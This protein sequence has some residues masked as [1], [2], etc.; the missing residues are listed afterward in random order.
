[1]SNLST[2]LPA[3]ASGKTI[4]ATA[5][6]AIATKKP[7]ILNSA[8][9]VTEVAETGVDGVDVAFGTAGVFESAGVSS[10]SSA[11]DSENNKV[12][13]AYRDEGNSSYGTAVVGTV[14]GTSISYG[15][16]VVFESASTNECAVAF[17]SN[18]NKIVIAYKD[19]GNSQY[20]TS[21]VGTVSG[22]AISF[23]S[24]VL[25]LS[26]AA[27]QAP[28]ITFDSTNN[29]VVIAYY[30]WTGSANQG[31]G[32]VGTVSGTS[33]SWG[34]AGSMTSGQSSTHQSIAYD[35][36][37]GKVVASYRNSGNSDYGTSS[38]GTVSGTSIS[39]GTPVVFEAANS[40]NTASA[41][42]SN[43]DKVVIAYTDYANSSHGTAIVGTVSGTSISFGTAVV[44]EAASTEQISAAFN[45]NT[46]KVE[47]AYRDVGNSNYGTAILGTVSGTAISFGDP[48]VYEAATVEFN[49]AVFDTDSNKIVIS[50]K[51]AGNSSYGTGIVSG[52]LSS[53]MT[54]ANFLG[55]ADAAIADDA[56]GTIVVR[57]GTVT[58]LGAASDTLTVSAGVQYDGGGGWMEKNVIVYDTNAN[59]V[60]V[61]YKDA[62]NS[63]H[64]TA[65]VGTI[66]GGTTTWG[67]P[68]V[69]NTAS[70]DHIG[71]A[72]DASAQKIVIAWGQGSSNSIVGT[73]SGTTITFGNKA[74]IPV[75]DGP[76]DCYIA[77]DANAQKVVLITRELAVSG[78]ERAYVGT[79]SGSGASQAVAWGSGTVWLSG[80]VR[81]G[82]RQMSCA[83]DSNAQKIAINY[84]RDSDSYCYGLVGTVSGSSISFGTATAYLSSAS[85]ACA[86]VYD[87]TAQKVVFA[88]RDNNDD[89]SAI[90]GTIS[91]TGI[92]FGTAATIGT[93]NMNEAQ[94]LAYDPDQN[95][96]IMATVLSGD[97]GVLNVGTVSGTGISFGSATAFE[98][99]FAPSHLSMVYDTGSD[100][101][102]L[103]YGYYTGSAGNSL[104]RVINTV[105]PFVTAS[106]YY[107]QS[108]G[109]FGTSASSPSVKAG[110]TLTTTSLLLT[111]D[112]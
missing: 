112:S 111:G 53:N 13:T 64:G 67:T 57:G 76:Y 91:G 9:T 24:P 5:S 103:V 99:D 14:S 87:S 46:N 104:A 110:K 94:R 65:A 25:Y 54:A 45:S 37:T 80:Q 78:D 8:G 85:Y 88:F 61:I 84:A 70:T 69:F 47:I 79:V 93:T 7:V 71:A 50:Y 29:K 55:F 32:K 26:G 40:P 1:M 81:S 43:S 12:V 3:G 109:S 36:N 95:V 19:W 68:V 90:V 35:A 11:F 44:F 59:K 73:V 52:Y 22:T 2:L 58:G 39:W 33:I 15:T 63:S 27:P 77:Y 41:Y 16:P 97:N 74:S 107:V 30:N 31:Y 66:S 75:S 23:G 106:N 101:S 48:V 92:S 72:Y 82:S 60:V 10:I 6:G 89:S 102:V 83:Y 86:S 62:G 20:G 98:A 49:S 42:D 28:A 100:K 21:I 38:V 105:T 108:D 51:D 4:D 56:T 34:G 96:T 17:D 18:S